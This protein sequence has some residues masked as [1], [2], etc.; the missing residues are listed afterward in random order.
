M[1]QLKTA[2]VLFELLLERQSLSMVLM[3][4]YIAPG[5]IAGARETMRS[6]KHST[7]TKVAYVQ[8]AF[9]FLWIGITA[10]VAYGIALNPEKFSD[11]VGQGQSIV[12][13]LVASCT[14]VALAVPP[15]L[16]HR[17]IKKK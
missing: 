10:G 3:M 16:I 8:F 2:F 9:I 13:L 5:I 14:M 17:R 15:F 1:E 12:I 6:Q 11:P 7:Q 4:L